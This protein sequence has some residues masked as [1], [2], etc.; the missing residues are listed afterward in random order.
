[1]LLRSYIGNV[2]EASPVGS[3]IVDSSS[4]RHAPLVVEATDADMGPNALLT[5]SIADIVAANVFEIDAATGA[6]SEHAPGNS[7]A[8]VTI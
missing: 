6:V 2:S 3:Y 7:N 5:Y 8:R 4:L 1:V